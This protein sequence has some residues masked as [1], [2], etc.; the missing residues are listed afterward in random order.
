VGAPNGDRK[1]FLPLLLLDLNWATWAKQASVNDLGGIRA[2]DL[3]FIGAL[4]HQ[5]EVFQSGYSFFAGDALVA[6]T[7]RA[8]EA[9][10]AN[11]KP[12]LPGFLARSCGLIFSG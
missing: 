2:R 6:G 7:A 11:N 12:A 9:Q 8:G 10:G 1:A 3:P 5:L 4:H